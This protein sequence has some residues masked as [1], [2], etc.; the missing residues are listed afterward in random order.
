MPL[1][2]DGAETEDERGQLTERYRDEK[3]VR[4]V[5]MRDLHV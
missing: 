4:D 1:W 2:S 3:V 5:V